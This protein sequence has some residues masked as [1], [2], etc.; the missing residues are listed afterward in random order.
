MRLLQLGFV[1]ACC[2]GLTVAAPVFGAGGEDAP[3]VGPAS[4]LDLNYELYVGGISL[5]KVAMS[6][7]IQGNDYKAI[8]SL[9]TKGIVNVFWQAKI[10]TSSSGSAARDRLNPSLYDSFSQNRSVQRQHATV[11]FGPD[12]P[13]T[14]TSDP[15]YRENKYSVSE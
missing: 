12:G 3:A 10:E 7:R 11:L 4:T 15:P 6:S 5:G 1:G 13:K 8:S 14:V 9:E 2:A